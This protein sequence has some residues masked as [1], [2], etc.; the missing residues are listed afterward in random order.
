[1]YKAAAGETSTIKQEE[2]ARSLSAGILARVEA[3]NEVTDTLEKVKAE[4]RERDEALEGILRATEASD[5]I[6]AQEARKA[7]EGATNG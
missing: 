1:L 5:E 6:V 3:R 4:I 2:F 7:K